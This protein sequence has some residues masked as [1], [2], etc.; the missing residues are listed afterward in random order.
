MKFL[1]CGLQWVIILAILP[2]IKSLIDAGVPILT[3][4][5]VAAQDIAWI[6]ILPWLIPLC[7]F[8]GTIIWMVSPSKPKSPNVVGL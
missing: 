4:Q 3:A 5:G 6:G 7:W 8:A 1:A 2:G